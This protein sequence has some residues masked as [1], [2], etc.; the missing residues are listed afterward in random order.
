MLELKTLLVSVLLI[1]NA[2]AAIA[3]SR[4]VIK[5]KVKARS[6][7]FAFG[8]NLSFYSKSDITFKSAESPSYNFTLHNVG[9]KDDQGLKFNTGGAPQYSYQLG[10][11]NNRKK[12]GIEFNFDHI[13]YIMR[14]YQR[15]HLVGNINGEPYDADTLITPDFISFEHT[16]GANYA[17]LKWVNRIQFLQDKNQRELLSLLVKAGGG[18]VIPKTNSTIMG[19]K[20]DDYY[21]ISGYVIALEAGLRYNFSKLLFAEANAKGAYADYRRFLIA[22]GTGSQRWFGLHFNLLVG[23]QLGM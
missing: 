18:P 8:T 3:Q 19:K 17:L 2:H 6:F 7:Y 22:D 4:T 1:V 14:Q 12:W 9:A 21:K 16:D 23:L 15:V 5:D 11:Y 20:K 10:Y 13:K